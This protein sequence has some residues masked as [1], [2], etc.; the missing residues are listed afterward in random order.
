MTFD[1]RKSQSSKKH[2]HL[3][4]VLFNKA[5][6]TSISQPPLLT[7]L[8]HSQPLP[9]TPNHSQPLPTTLNHFQ[10]L[11]TTPNNS[12]PLST[13]PNHTQPLRSI[14]HSSDWNS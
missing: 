4:C 14:S 3:A 12:Q 11:P 5:W 13:T 10:P 7:T 1:G 6:M 2:S 8:K 9:T